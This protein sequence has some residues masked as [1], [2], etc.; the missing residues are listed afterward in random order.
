MTVSQMHEVVGNIHIHTPYSDG[1]AFH[2]DIVEA[3]IQAGLDFIITTDHNVYVEG[4]EGYYERNDGRLL[5]IMGEEIHNPRQIPGGDHLLVIGAEHELSRL[6]ANTQSV[7]DAAAEQDGLTFLAHPHDYAAEQFGEGE[8]S[9]RNWEVSGYTGIELWNYMSEFKG[10]LKNYLA[11]AQILLQP[12]RFISGPTADMLTHW[13][14]LQSYQQHV[15]AIAGSDA[16]ALHRTLG[17]F[18]K[19]IFPYRYLFRCVN[20]HVLL[21]TPL[22][23]EFED[24]KSRILDALKIGRAWIGY[25][26]PASTS[27][28]RFSAQGYN[29][30]TVVGGTMRLRHGVTL[31]VGIPQVGIIRLIRNGELYQEVTDNTYKSFIINQPGIYRVEAYIDYKGKQRGWIF[32]NPIYIIQ[33][34]KG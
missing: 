14:S 11:A 13:D 10:H 31:Q 33:A 9:W 30:T 25:D 5:L 21:N 17:P 8:F 15:I 28:F 23:G 27:G 18:S 34:N 29:F 2:G 1:S 3:A 22:S 16:H 20:T 12:D 26:L 4:V 6:S 7:I 24:D 32:S 19:I